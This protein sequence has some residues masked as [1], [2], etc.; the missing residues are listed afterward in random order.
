[1]GNNA[2][3]DALTKGGAIRDAITIKN[4]YKFKALNYLENVAI[5]QVGREYLQKLLK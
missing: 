3:E 5:N 4:V 2:T 1:M